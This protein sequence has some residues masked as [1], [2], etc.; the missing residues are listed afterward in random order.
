M[1]RDKS[2]NQE[3]GFSVEPLESRRMLAGDFLATFGNGD[4][5]F[6]KG[7]RAGN[8]VD[9]VVDGD[10]SVLLQGRNGTTINGQASIDTG[11]DSRNL[12]RVR[13]AGKKGDDVVRFIDNDINGGVAGNDDNVDF[14]IQNLD[15]NLGKANDKVVIRDT[16][17]ERRTNIVTSFGDD[18]VLLQNNIFE[19][20]VNVNTG[21]NADR[22]G[23]DSNIFAGVTRVTAGKGNDLVQIDR[24]AVTTNSTTG[25][26]GVNGFEGAASANFGQINGS[27][28]EDRTII[29]LGPGGDQID[30]GRFDINGNAVAFP[31][32]DALSAADVNFANNLGFT[33]EADLANA[34]FTF[35]LN[36]D[37]VANVDIIGSHAFDTI[38]T[39][40]DGAF[41]EVANPGGSV[42]DVV[43]PSSFDVVTIEAPAAA[44]PIIHPVLFNQV[45]I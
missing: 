31:Q 11:I 27:I 38:F 33:R 42:F 25:L 39:R 6:L 41:D 8:Q 37:R 44:A 2:K 24:Q 43:G 1:K 35:N 13:V 10:G 40:T 4:D 9:F 36:T 18:T 20:T 5:I 26:F 12:D 21:K 23:I 34:N 14:V 32:L 30:I 17:V 15:I 22:I 7:D 16:V 19:G 45:I 29:N 3:L 28:F